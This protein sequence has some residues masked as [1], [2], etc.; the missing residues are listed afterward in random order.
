MTPA[1]SHVDQISIRPSAEVAGCEE[2]L[3]SGGQW[4]HLRQCL[5]C[6]RVGCCDSSR[7]RHA[8]EHAAESSHPIVCSAEPGETWCWCYVDELAFEVSFE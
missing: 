2:C 1:C 7:N 4:V 3:R 6:G 8:S 5:S